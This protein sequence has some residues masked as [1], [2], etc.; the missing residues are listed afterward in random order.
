[1]NKNLNERK[2]PVP[3]N[4]K[5]YNI[6]RW[7]LIIPLLTLS[8]TVIDVYDKSS[9]CAS[10]LLSDM[11]SVVICAIEILIIIYLIVSMSQFK[12]SVYIVNNIFMYAEI[13]AHSAVFFWGIILCIGYEDYSL[14]GI[15]I[16][17][18]SPLKIIFCIVN[19]VY[20]HRRKY[21][22]RGASMKENISSSKAAIPEECNYKESI[23]KENEI[24]HFNF[25]D[26]VFADDETISRMEA[27]YAE[28]MYTYVS[29]QIKQDNDSDKNK[30][31][32]LKKYNAVKD[33]CTS[34]LNKIKTGHLIVLILCLAAIG[35]IVVSAVVT[36][37]GNTSAIKQSANSSVS[38]AKYIGNASSRKFHKKSCSHLPN[39][40]NQVYYSTREQAIKDG[41]EPC[42]VC[43]P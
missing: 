43:E 26:A 35:A 3:N 21:L 13:I 6:Y 40:D 32:A 1:M 23:N 10:I 42:K 4:M 27:E 9:N 33:A 14:L 5:W 11:A 36:H 20:F 12:K 37:S 15:S 17:A 16:S 18:F 38:T 34:T 7:I 29:N 25:N 31:V 8:G 22:F 41:M 28:K 39:K 19:A 24:P 30:T 2:P